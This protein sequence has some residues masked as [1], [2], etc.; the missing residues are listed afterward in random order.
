ME[1][2]GCTAPRAGGARSHKFQRACCGTPTAAHGRKCMRGWSHRSGP[3]PALAPPPNQ[4][5]NGM[6][7][8]Q[9]ASQESHGLRARHL[10]ALT[11]ARSPQ[12]SKVCGGGVTPLNSRRKGSTGG[13]P[14]ALLSSAAP[15]CC[16]CCCGHRRQPADASM[17]PR[18]VMQAKPDRTPSRSSWCQGASQ[19]AA[20]ILSG[21]AIPLGG[22]PLR[23][24]GCITLDLLLGIRQCPAPTT[25]GYCRGGGPQVVGWGGGQ[26][27]SSQNRCPGRDSLSTQEQLNTKN[28]VLLGF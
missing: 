5:H 3:E 2:C 28:L 1:A 18:L 19:D 13:P 17:S 7:H 12:M 27:T 23:P 24:R 10:G 8:V 20:G 4:T 15:S 26:R 14:A 21:A 11:T 25:S 16:C 9:L 6:A 22:R